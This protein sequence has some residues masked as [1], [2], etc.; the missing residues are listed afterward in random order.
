MQLSS[1]ARA[2]VR[3]C[4]GGGSFVGRILRGFVFSNMSPVAAIRISLFLFFV[5]FC[6]NAQPVTGLYNFE[7]A[8]VKLPDIKYFLL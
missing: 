6:Y 1:C 2:R 5:L 8:S 4:V 3:L 7:I